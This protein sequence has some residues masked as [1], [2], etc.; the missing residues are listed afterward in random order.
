MDF[1]SSRCRAIVDAAGSSN[2]TQIDDQHE[3][4]E[5]SDVESPDGTVMHPRGSEREA[6]DSSLGDPF[7]KKRGHQADTQ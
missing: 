4:N 5:E 3:R 1:E 6:G 7:L 2:S